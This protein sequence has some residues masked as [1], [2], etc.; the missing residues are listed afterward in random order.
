MFSRIF[1][2]NL[3]TTFTRGQS[4][5]RGRLADGS[6]NIRDVPPT[7]SIRSLILKEKAET[8][9]PPENTFEWTMR[10]MADVQ[11]GVPKLREADS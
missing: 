10:Y 1:R 6:P 3:W 11:A 2:K 8:I 9:D 5:P 4:N 7:R